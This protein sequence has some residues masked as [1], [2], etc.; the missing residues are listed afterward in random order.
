MRSG[1]V[2]EAHYDLGNDLYETMLDSRMVYTCAYWRDA[3]TL[4]Q[5]QVHKLRLCCEKLG[6]AP[7]MHVLDVG[8]GWGGF[9]EYAAMH[10]GVRVTGVTISKEQAKLARERCVNLPVD[11]RV[12]DYREITGT[13]DR[14][15]SLGMFEHVGHKNYRTFMEIMAARLAP[16]GSLLLQT[17]GKNDSTLGVDPWID[18]YI[19]P[20]GEIPSLRQITDAVEGLFVIEDVHN[21]GPDYARTLRAWYTN[22]RTGWH[23][24]RGRYPEKFFRLWRYYLLSCAGAFSARNLQLWQIVMNRGDVFKTFV[25]R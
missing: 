6:L 8:C 16:Q 7:G 14:I 13:Y 19:F 18:R 11:I 22:F 4:E 2:A 9:A 3:S 20:N 23:R 12:C 24:L 5:A 25:R 15:V 1:Q 17:I 10:Y 21:F